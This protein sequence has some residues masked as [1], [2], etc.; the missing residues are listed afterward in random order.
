MYLAFWEKVKANDGFKDRW[1]SS[2][3][4][5]NDDDPRRLYGSLE[6]DVFELIVYGGKFVERSKKKVWRED[7][8][9]HEE[10]KYNFKLEN[11]SRKFYF[12]W[13][14]ELNMNIFMS[15]NQEF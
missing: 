8:M 11:L 1:F 12:V 7:C 2:T 13:R 15:W 9:I 3:L 5:S 4:G 10:E 14:V 6:A